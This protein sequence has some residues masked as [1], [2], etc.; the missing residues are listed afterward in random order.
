M[1]DLGSGTFIDFSKYNLIREPRVQESVAS[2]VDVVTFSGD[3]LLGGPQAGIIAGSRD[4]LDRIKQ[5][6]LTRA[7][8]I[9]KLTLAALESTLRLYRDEARAMEEIPTLRMLTLAVDILEKRAGHLADML[10]KAGGGHMTVEVVKGTS[11]AGGGSLPLAD[12]P[13]FCVRVGVPS[14]SVNR[15]ER[16]LRGGHPPI[17][18]R[19]ED[20]RYVMDVRTIEEQEYDIVA[21]AFET[22]LQDHNH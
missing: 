20:D 11:R 18:G 21:R 3:K 8:R 5:N 1:E 14:L 13:T 12:L 9:D 17:I 15:L 7:L 6:P 2:G 10:R 16:L 4:I 19:I 22:I